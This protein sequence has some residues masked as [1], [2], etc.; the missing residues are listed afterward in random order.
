MPQP[1]FLTANSRYTSKDD[2]HLV[3]GSTFAASSQLTFSEERYRSNLRSI[4]E[5]CTDRQVYSTDLHL[6]QPEFEKMTLAPAEY[7]ELAIDNEI[8]FPHCGSESAMH[9]I[10]D[11]SSG[12]SMFDLENGISVHGQEFLENKNA[13][14]VSL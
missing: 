11:Q 1:Q 2:S 8:L 7:E 14:P 3:E 5:E 9:E 10:T 13:L 12:L 6:H 4:E